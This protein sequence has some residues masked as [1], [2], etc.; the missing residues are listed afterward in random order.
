[1]Q[2]DAIPDSVDARRIT[3][4]S[5]SG[6]RDGRHE[7]LEDMGA[8]FRRISINVLTIVV[9][10]VL[11]LAGYWVYDNRQHIQDYFDANDFTP[12]QRMSETLSLL[13][14]TPAGD[15]IFRA[16]HP[17][18][19]GR[20]VFNDS[21]QRADV[22]DEG[23]LLGCYTNG[24][25]HLFEVNDERLAG[26][27][28]VTAAHELLH[29]VY[30]RMPIRD[31]EALAKRL[32]L[33]YREVSSLD[34]DFV[35]RMSVY[36][37]LSPARFANELHSVYATEVRELPEWLEE[38]YRAWFANRIAV[39]DLFDAY[40]ALFLQVRQDIEVLEEELTGLIDWIE[41]ES[42]RYADAVDMFN[43]DWDVFTARNENYE[44]SANPEEFYHLRDQF[45]HR[46]EILDEWRVNIE[47]EISEYDRIV[48]ELEDLG[49][50]T[51]DLN[52]HLDSSLPSTSTDLAEP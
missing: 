36:S 24:R 27:V 12:T 14:L 4:L 7:I 37:H 29:A 19:E 8:T 41:R 28:E 39:V 17:T 51:M 49:K 42:G 47:R 20:D 34:A 10:L 1:M 44:F 30:E 46:R 13:Q 38:H 22:G 31:Q 43:A 23:H 9:V 6:S 2:N 11:A 18:V 32:T 15:R 16:T 45:D 50:L 40:H 25:I 5:S 33:H 48:S 26:V 52:H 3:I 35:E 21:C